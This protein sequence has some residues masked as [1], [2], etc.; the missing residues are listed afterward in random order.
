MDNLQ[1]FKFS[2]SN[3]RMG[4]IQRCSEVT[5]ARFINLC[6]LY[7][8]KECTLSYE[9]A[10]IEIEKEHLDILIRKKIV[11]KSDDFINISFLDEQFSEI[12]E[13]SNNRSLSGV[14]GNL[15]RWHK[16]IYK[17]Y[18]NKEITLD[19][20]IR[21][22]KSVATQ[23]LPDSNP[24]ATQSQSIADKNRGEE[25]RKE[26][27]QSIDWG[28]LIEYIN[29]KTG[30][31]FQLINDKLKSK[32]RARLKEGYTKDNIRF[33]IDNAIKV[34]THIDNGFQY[35]TPEFFSRSDTLDKYGME[36]KETGKDKR[37]LAMEEQIRK[38]GK[39]E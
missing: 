14:I 32:Y 3:W 24:I 35:L 9:D 26:K 31:R 13:K 36:R 20:A 6:C 37:V 23:S 7:W 5:Q 33:A 17:R 11:L 8:S 38:Y 4:K 15:K 28:I 25:I 2:F 39:S 27:K 22:S 19:E 30:R 18:E 34:Q 29:E 21:L 1:W 12:E 10:E 16:P